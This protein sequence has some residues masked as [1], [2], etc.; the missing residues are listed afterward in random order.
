LR[1]APDYCLTFGF[2]Q[3]RE[4]NRQERTDVNADARALNGDDTAGRVRTELERH[5]VERA[6]SGYQDLAEWLQAQRLCE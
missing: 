3:T 2:L 4:R 1:A 5:I 6:F